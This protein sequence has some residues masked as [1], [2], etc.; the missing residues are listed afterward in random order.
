MYFDSTEATCLQYLVNHHLHDTAMNTD[1]N[2]TF[3]YS[4]YINSEEF[5]NVDQNL[6]LFSSH[7]QR[8]GQ[9]T[10]Q[11]VELSESPCKDGF[12]LGLET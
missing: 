12:R 8:S 3:Q 11:E 9:F 6:D 2:I 5:E 7:R 10:C 1:N 4:V